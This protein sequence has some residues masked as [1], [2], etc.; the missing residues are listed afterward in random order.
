MRRFS[1]GISRRFALDAVAPV[2]VVLTAPSQS[3]LVVDLGDIRDVCLE[4]WRSDYLIG[5]HFNP[6]LDGMCIMAGTQR[7]VAPVSFA[8]RKLTEAS[9]RGRRNHQHEG[10]WALGAGARAS[11]SWWTYAGRLRARRYR[12]MCVLGLEGASCSLPEKLIS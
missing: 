1:F 2:G 10:S 8:G 7:F 12:A 5:A 11:W 4:P 3:A 9:Q 6:A